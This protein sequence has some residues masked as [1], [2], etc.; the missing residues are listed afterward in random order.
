MNFTLHIQPVGKP[1]MVRGDKWKQRPCVMEYRAFCDRLRYK[2]WGENKKQ[3]LMKPT[4]LIVT[5]FFQPATPALSG[6]LVGEPYVKKP[7]SS[8]ILKAV[9]DALF[10]NDEMIFS[11]TCKKYW[12][13]SS[14]HIT[15]E[16]SE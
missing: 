2:A 10:S 1:T 7:D 14:T 13:F 12:G 3:K 11:S 9:E 5:C 8:N 6:Q 4:S 16:W 15:V